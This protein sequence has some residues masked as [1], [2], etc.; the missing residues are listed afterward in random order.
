MKAYF[1]ITTE[2]LHSYFNQPGEFPR[3]LYIFVLYDYETNILCVSKATK[4][5][6]S[7]CMAKHLQHP[8][9]QS[10]SS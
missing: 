3:N 8:S 1:F 7:K 5:Q 6:Y 9:I 2:S 10:I 4:S